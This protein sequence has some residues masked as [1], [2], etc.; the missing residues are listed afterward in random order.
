MHDC[1]FL[2]L[3]LLRIRIRPSPPS[4]SLPQ[5][6]RGSARVLQCLAS[7]GPKEVPDAGRVLKGA[8]FK[9]ALEAMLRKQGKLASAGGALA[10]AARAAH[11]AIGTLHPKAS[12]RIR[13]ILAVAFLLR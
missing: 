2:A 3:N 12:A 1:L 9:E 5:L 13:L 4:P 8:A 7:A 6:I 10:K 11:A